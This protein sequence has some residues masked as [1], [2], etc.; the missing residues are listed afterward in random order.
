MTNHQRHPI[1]E[2]FDAARKL[3]GPVQEALAAEII[4]RIEQ[5]GH[6]EMTDAQRAEVKAR[7]SAP[8]TYAEPASV[9]DF[10]RRHG[11]AE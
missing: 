11:V 5:L 10:F 2:A 1:D 8:A 6:T 4:A 3:P 9:R 7:L